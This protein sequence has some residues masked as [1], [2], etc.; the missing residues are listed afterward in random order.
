MDDSSQHYSDHG[1]FSDERVSFPGSLLHAGKNTLTVTMNAKSGIAYL[2]VDYLRLELTGYVPAAPASVTAFPGN[3][4]VLVR[5]PVVPGATSYNVLRAAAGGAYA[6]VA[7]G[8]VGPVCGSDVAMANYTDQ[9]AA[10]GTPYSYAVQSVNPAG[11]SAASVPSPGCPPTATA[12]ASAPGTPTG[13]KVASSGHHQVALNWN[14]SPGAN[15]YRIVRTTLHENGV[16]GFYPLRSIVLNDA[17]AGTGFVDNTP[18][19]GTRYSYSVEA[20][21]AAGLSGPSAAVMAVP[22]PPPP[23]SAPQSLTGT[24]TKSRQG[25]GITLAWS[26]VPGAVGYTIYRSTRPDGQFRWPED[27][28]TTL[29]E[30]TYTDRNNPKRA[31]QKEDDHLKPG[32]DYYYQVTAVNAAGSRH[33][34]GCMSAISRTDRQHGVTLRKCPSGGF[35]CRVSTTT[36]TPTILT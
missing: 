25:P 32:T 2:M 16:G 31:N 15:Y 4:R 34:R 35:I 3:N 27:F 10:N 12:P 13:L 30:T 20:A 33:P 22:L 17:V 18:T 7:T 14:A 21:N 28:V 11:H 9:T 29:V 5:W 8:L 19:D 26:P 36:A 24:W 1:P 6:P 23:G